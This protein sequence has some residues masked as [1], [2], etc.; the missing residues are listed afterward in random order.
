MMLAYYSLLKGSLILSTPIS[1]KEVIRLATDQQYR[2]AAAAVAAG[3]A[4]SEQIRLNNKMAANVRAGS[5]LAQ[6]AQDAQKATG[7]K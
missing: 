2:N 3:T 4:T 6:G 5:S 1:P 7:K